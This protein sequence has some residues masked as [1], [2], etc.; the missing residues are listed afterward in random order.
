MAVF[1]RCLGPSFAAITYDGISCAEFRQRVQVVII[2]GRK[3]QDFC[4]TNAPARSIVTV[5]AAQRRR[6]TGATLCLILC[7]I[8]W[9]RMCGEHQTVRPR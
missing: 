3:A 4:E 1:I 7:L 5:W 9:P 8:L 2:C 6:P